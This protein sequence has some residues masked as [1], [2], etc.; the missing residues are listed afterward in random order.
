MTNAE[1]LR[2]QGLEQGL[3]RGRQQSL[4]RLMTLRFGPLPEAVTARI[5]AA[6]LELLDRWLELVLTADSPDAV[7][8]L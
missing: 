7:V 8:E 3:A 4:E 6:N 5:H 1:E 2:A